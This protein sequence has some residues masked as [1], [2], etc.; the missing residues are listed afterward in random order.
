MH[1][2]FELIDKFKLPLALSL[3][4][5]TLIVGGFLASGLNKSKPKEFPKESMVQSEKIISVD[6]SGA[7]NKDGV[8]QLKEGQRIED[9]V[10]AAGGFSNDANQE[11]ISK[12]INMAQKLVD[13]TKIYIPKNG[14][15]MATSSN[16]SSGAGQVAGV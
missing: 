12:Y 9:A 14:D 10:N 5:L 11:Y 7:V 3:V 8:Y 6:V 16:G 13:G 4:G 2:S 15:S 1:N